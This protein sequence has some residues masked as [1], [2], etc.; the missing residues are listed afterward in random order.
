[1]LFAVAA[2]L[3]VGF[4]L[5]T[6]AYRY[7]FLRVP[8]EPVIA[9][10]ERELNLTPAQRSQIHDIMRDARLRIMQ[11]E[12]DFRRQRRQAFLDA[13]H[14]IRGTLTPEQQQTFDREFLPY[15]AR[16]G[17]GEG[18]M[19]HPGPPGPPPPPPPQ[20]GDGGL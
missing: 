16:R 10:M 1:M 7:R 5:S 15:A 18:P 12:R 3:L 13:L 8:G 20:D 2:A 19:R 9:R 14:Q 17:W 6:L 4:A 11:S